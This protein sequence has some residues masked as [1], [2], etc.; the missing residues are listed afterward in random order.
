[1]EDKAK[2]IEAL[3]NKWD[4]EIAKMGGTR[5]R[6]SR[7]A[8]EGGSKFEKIKAPR[9]LENECIEH[10]KNVLNFLR[11]LDS[12]YPEQVTTGLGCLSIE[13]VQKKLK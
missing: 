11:Y 4:G 6:L 12:T 7:A 9:D 8:Q 5:L 2:P 3:L 1:M 13:E 10:F